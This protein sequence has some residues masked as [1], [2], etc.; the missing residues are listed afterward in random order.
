MENP[1]KEIAKIAHQLPLVVLQDINKRITDWMASGGKD[2][3]PYIEQQLRFAQNVIK[4]KHELE[5]EGIC[6][7]S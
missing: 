2:D 5:K 7:G 3:D 4:R 6:F 1:I